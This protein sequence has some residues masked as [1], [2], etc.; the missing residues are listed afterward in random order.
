ML[1]SYGGYHATP[2]SGGVFSPGLVV[3]VVC[4]RP[5]NLCNGARHVEIRQIILVL[6]ETGQIFAL[7]C[8]SVLRFVVFG[9]PPSPPSLASPME[10]PLMATMFGHWPN[11]AE[12][13]H[14]SLIIRP[15]DLGKWTVPNEMVSD[16]GLALPM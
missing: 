10:L 11:M 4:P 2:S 8:T 1:L 12:Q 3:T 5:W 6:G 7:T 9:N 14:G 16:F 13:H 15:S